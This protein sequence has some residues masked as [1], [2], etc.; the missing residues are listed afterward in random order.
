M[1][2]GFAHFRVYFATAITT[3]GSTDKLGH[4]SIIEYC[5]GFIDLPGLY[6]WQVSV[7]IIVRCVLLGRPEFPQDEC[8][9][10]VANHG[11]PTTS[12]SQHSGSTASRNHGATAS[13]FAPGI[14]ASSFVVGLA[15]VEAA[16]TADSYAIFVRVFL[17]LVA[18]SIWELSVSRRLSFPA[19]SSLRR[20]DQMDNIQRAS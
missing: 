15:V 3:A 10:L 17:V 7:G 13:T 5:W 16:G 6:W 18:L 9:E 19:F 12:S 8:I 20:V 2:E 4:Y 14:F 1:A 11:G